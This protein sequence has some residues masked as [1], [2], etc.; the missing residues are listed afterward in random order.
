M[1]YNI[2]FPHFSTADYYMSEGQYLKNEDMNKLLR[3]SSDPKEYPHT[4]Y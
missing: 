1:H 2:I 3:R 4:H